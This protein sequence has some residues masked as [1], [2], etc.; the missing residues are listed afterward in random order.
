MGAVDLLGETVGRGVGVPVDEVLARVRGHVAFEVRV[1]VLHPLVDHRDGHVGAPEG[2]VPGRRG[3][4]LLVGVLVVVARV[5]R[6]VERLVGRVLLGVLDVVLLR[7]RLDEVRSGDRSG[8]S[9]ELHRDVAQR[10]VL[11]DDLGVAGNRPFDGGSH[12]VLGL[13]NPDE[14]LPLLR[15]GFA[16]RR[17]R[18]DATETAEQCAGTD[19]FQKPSS[20][21]IGSFDH[22]STPADGRAGIKYYLDFSK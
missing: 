14:D 15:P 3:I 6:P 8:P 13:R 18:R 19:G 5:V 17:R 22:C 9:R 2:F 10:L 21:A 16:P 7:D 11:V 1:V 4:D 20:T 12:P